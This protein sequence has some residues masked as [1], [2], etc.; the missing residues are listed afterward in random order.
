[1]RVFVT[2]GTTKFDSLIHTILS[3]D[4]QAVLKEKNFTQMVIQYGKSDVFENILS[5][6]PET[7]LTSESLELL[8]TFSLKPNLKE[9]ITKAD[10]VI[11][12]AGAGTCLEGVYIFK[13]SHILFTAYVCT[14]SDINP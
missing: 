10:L 5:Q 1:M 11:G 3:T 2:V 13:F 9:D 12:H 6:T 8:E 7:L 4:V 14:Y